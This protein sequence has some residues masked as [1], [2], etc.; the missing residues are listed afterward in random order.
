[1]A[2]GRVS[3]R[4]GSSRALHRGTRASWGGGGGDAAVA[5]KPGLRAD[6]PAA[7]RRGPAPQLAR[8]RPLRGDLTPWHH[9][10]WT[11]PARH[12]RQHV[13]VP[14]DVDE[15]TQR[16]A[17]QQAGP[18]VIGRDAPS[19]CGALGARALDGPPAVIRGATGGG[20]RMRVSRLVAIDW[21]SCSGRRC[22]RGLGTHEPNAGQAVQSNRAHGSCINVGGRST[23]APKWTAA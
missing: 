12:R 16:S 1:M 10:G 18:G 4:R 15:G 3:R 14:P 9:L 20:N 7:A 2:E 6:R 22:W 17:H 11:T 8:E 19:S 21:G 23:A 5:Y 13:Y